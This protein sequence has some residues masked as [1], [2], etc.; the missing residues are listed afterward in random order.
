MDAEKLISEIEALEHIFSL[1]DPR[2]L[3]P[4][5]RQSISTTT[6]D[7]PTIRGSSSGI[8]TGGSST[9]GGYVSFK[10]RFT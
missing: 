6:R 9:L 1:S 3:R 2:P 7:S 10:R 8:P 4:T 5:S